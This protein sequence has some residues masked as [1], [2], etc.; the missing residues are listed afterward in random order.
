M[1]P[2]IV[3]GIGGVVLIVWGIICAVF[4][5]WAAG[6]GKRTQ[7]IYGQAAADQV[8]PGRIRFIGIALALGGVLFVIL[9]LTGVLPNRPE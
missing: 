1:N 5:D 8:T 2:A 3:F 7:R 6:L 9:A 4:N